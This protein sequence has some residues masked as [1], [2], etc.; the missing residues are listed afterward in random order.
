M[1]HD[2]N[3]THAARTQTVLT[4]HIHQG[5]FVAAHE[6]RVRQEEMPPVGAGHVDD[7]HRRT[8][9]QSRQPLLSLVETA[10]SSGPAFALLECG[11]LGLNG[12]FPL[13]SHHD[14]ATPSERRCR[15]VLG[16]D[17]KRRHQVPIFC[18]SLDA[19]LGQ[20]ERRIFQNI[21]LPDGDT[22][23]PVCVPF[24]LAPGNPNPR[25]HEQGTEHSLLQTGDS[26]RLHPSSGR[27][28]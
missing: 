20:S 17:L 25:K 8:E 16:C 6:S 5:T 9:R 18:P 24:V 23:W 21:R 15:P 4:K 26:S 2:P 1:G 28:C 10:T 19:L 13:D 14:T 27:C 3:R 12:G 7:Q 22:H 11:S